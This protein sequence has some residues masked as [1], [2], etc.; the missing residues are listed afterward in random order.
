LQ[1]RYKRN[2]L[3]PDEVNEVLQESG[4]VSP[5]RFEEK[6]DELRKILSEDEAKEL[7]LPIVANKVWQYNP[8]TGDAVL[9]GVAPP[10]RSGITVWDVQVNNTPHEINLYQDAQGK[11]RFGG[12]YPKLGPK[13]VIDEFVPPDILGAMQR[14][15]KDAGG[16]WFNIG[17]GP[18]NSNDPLGIKRSVKR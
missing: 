6:P 4:M 2:E 1:Y 12:T 8:E 18:A 3:T 17:G 11:Y 14:S 9:K 16:N 13:A 7:D 5:E 10:T 15:Q